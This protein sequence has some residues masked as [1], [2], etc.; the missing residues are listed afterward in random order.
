MIG[1]GLE[2]AGLESRVASRAAS[3]ISD[4]AAA[5]RAVIEAYGDRLAAADVA[6]FVSRYTGNAAVMQPELETVVGSQ[7]LTVTY[8][9]AFENMRL[10]FTFRFGDI[11]VKGDLAAVGADRAIHVPADAGAVRRGL[12]RH[13]ASPPPG[14]GHVPHPLAVAERDAAPAPPTSTCPYRGRAGRR[15]LRSRPR[16]CSGRRRCWRSRLRPPMH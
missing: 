11:T 2:G 4:D 9:A 14:F 13:L 12:L 16:A 6:G 8:D 5:V 1:S 3:A 10:D 15:R 7:Q